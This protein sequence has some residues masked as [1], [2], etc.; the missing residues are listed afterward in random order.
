MAS[1][2]KWNAESIERGL[3]R[4]D[5]ITARLARIGR[6]LLVVLFVL[7]VLGGAAIG[8]SRGQLPTPATFGV[9]VEISPSSDAEGGES[10]GDAAPEP[11]GDCRGQALPALTLSRL[12][13]PTTW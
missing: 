8:I 12:A 9:D 4:G 7:A 5:S 6:N 11:G 13:P 10:G 1:L 2:R 3:E